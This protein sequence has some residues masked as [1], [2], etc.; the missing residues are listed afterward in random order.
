MEQ[1]KAQLVFVSGFHGTSKKGNAFNMT[2]FYQVVKN[3]ETGKIRGKEMTFFSD[4]E[5]EEWNTCQFG[6]VVECTLK[7]S[8]VLTEPPVLVSI[9]KVIETSPYVK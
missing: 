6:D 5:F 7:P 9:D 8:E 4:N 2:T 3:A 1:I